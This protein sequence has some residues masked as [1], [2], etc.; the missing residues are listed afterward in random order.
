[1][2]VDDVADLYSPSLDV[3]IGREL[4]ECLKAAERGAKSVEGFRVLDQVA[5]AMTKS[6]G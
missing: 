3:D 2:G 1:V 4:R 5:L 6:I